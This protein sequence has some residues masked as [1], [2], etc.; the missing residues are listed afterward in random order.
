M[1]SARTLSFALTLLV[2]PG[3]AAERVRLVVH[4]AP[5]AGAQY[6]ALDGLGTR[7]RVGDALT[8]VREP[9]N[10]HDPRAIRVEWRGV[11]LGYVPRRENRLL[12]A[13][14][15]AG[16]RLSARVAQVG[17]DAD[18]WRRLRFDVLSEL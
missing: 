18:P 9:D 11:K 8:L 5:L 4:S 15:D 2:A 7:L 14:L 3:T 6:Y 10:R 12:A 1:P 16:E 13:A 17:E